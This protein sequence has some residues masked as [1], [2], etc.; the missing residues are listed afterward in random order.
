MQ[1][2]LNVAKKKFKK[3]EALF[4]DNDYVV[5][6]RSYKNKTV[7]SITTVVKNEWVEVLGKV[8]LKMSFDRMVDKLLKTND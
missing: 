1:N 4:L 7:R 6:I 3:T 5:E 8:V 2:N